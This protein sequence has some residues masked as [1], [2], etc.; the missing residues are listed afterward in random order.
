MDRQEYL[1]QI[2]MKN[3]P[4]KKSK[5]GGVFGSKFFWVGVIGVAVFVFIMVLGGVL[6]SARGSDKDRLFALILHIDNTSEIIGEYQPNVKSSDLRSYSASLGGILSNTSKD[7]TEYATAKYNF[8][9]KDVKQNIIEEETTAKDALKDE[10]FEAKING[11]LDRIYAHKMAYEISL[12]ANSEAQLL[13]ST[14]N[15]TLKEML[16]TSYNSLDN[17]YDKFNDFSETK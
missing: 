2:S 6:G 10:F 17:L 3:Q 8:K 5:L 4:T 15:D 9:A 1:N 13:K 14:N 11:V 12:M 16:T 7:L